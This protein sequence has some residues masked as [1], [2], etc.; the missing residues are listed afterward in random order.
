MHSYCRASTA[1]KRLENRRPSGIAAQ[2]VREFV[3]DI[4]VNGDMDKLA[5]YRDGGKYIQHN[6]QIADGCPD[7]ALRRRPWQWKASP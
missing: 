4:P 5:G 3:D 2:P 1:A 7:L 6:P